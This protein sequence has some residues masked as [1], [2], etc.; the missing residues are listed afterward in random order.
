M[1]L[2]SHKYN[3]LDGLDGWKGDGQ[4]TRKCNNT[5]RVRLTTGIKEEKRRYQWT[6]RFENQPPTVSGPMFSSD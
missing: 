3:E 5:A 4:V 1:I 2:G 6:Q